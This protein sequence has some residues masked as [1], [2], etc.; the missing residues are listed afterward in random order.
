M[1]PAAASRLAFL[2]CTLLAGTASADIAAIKH[3]AAQ[4]PVSLDGTVDGVEDHAFTLRDASGH[5]RIHLRPDDAVVLKKG[6]EVSVTG[7]LHRSLLG[8]SIDA[9]SVQPHQSALK[10]IDEAA[11]RIPGMATAQVQSYD[12]RTL[13]TSGQVKVT[14]TVERVQNDTEFSL[15][16][17]TGSVAVRIAS[18]QR[19]VLTPG[20]KVTVIGK[21]AKTSTPRIDASDVLINAAAP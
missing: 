18:Q 13:P 3:G 10:A 15:A 7:T 19:A 6:D 8:N 1:K 21:I 14:G 17:D 2:G 16:D 5:I 11:K 4:Q 20:A 9:S 12:I